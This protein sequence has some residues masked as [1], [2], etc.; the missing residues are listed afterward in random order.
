M[1]CCKCARMRFHCAAGLVA[2][3]ICAAKRKHW[4]AH[5]DRRYVLAKNL[6]NAMCF[7]HFTSDRKQAKRRPSSIKQIATINCRKMPDS[8]IVIKQ[9]SWYYNKFSKS[10][11]LPALLGRG[12]GASHQQQYTAVSVHQQKTSQL[13]DWYSSDWRDHMGVGFKLGGK[14]KN[15]SAVQGI[16]RSASCRKKCLNTLRWQFIDKQLIFRKSRDPYCSQLEVVILTANNASSSSIN[17]SV[18]AESAFVI[19]QD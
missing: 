8:V 10:A 6:H 19:L 18:L 5:P 14:S 15:T 7:L 12:F 1:E 16:Q 9:G 11:A 17:Q 13:S 4:Q 2:L 3:H